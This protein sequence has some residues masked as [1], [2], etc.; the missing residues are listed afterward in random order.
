M[1][2][3]QR[4][5]EIHCL[6]DFPDNANYYSDIFRYKMNVS[7]YDMIEQC[8]QQICQLNICPMSIICSLLRYT[9]WG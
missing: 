3:F 6:M 9:T 4:V 2:N 7:I 5:F 8:L 1:L